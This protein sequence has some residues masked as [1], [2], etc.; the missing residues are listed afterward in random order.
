MQQIHNAAVFETDFYASAAQ[1]KAEKNWVEENYKHTSAGF[2]PAPLVKNVNQDK[3][4]SLTS[5]GW[6]GA[7]K[8]PVATFETA[9]QMRLNHEKS[10]TREQVYEYGA[11]MFPQK[12]IS[13]AIWTEQNKNMGKTTGTKERKKKKKDNEAHFLLTG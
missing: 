4:N 6:T 7:E 3:G 10:P 5:F 1:N 9:H 8:K 12:Q 2:T 13:D 11:M